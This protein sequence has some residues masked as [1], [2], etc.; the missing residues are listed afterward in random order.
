[1]QMLIQTYKTK[2]NKDLEALIKEK[3]SGYLQQ[4]FLVLLQ[5][6]WIALMGYRLTA[7]R[8]TLYIVRLTMLLR[9]TMRG[10]GNSA[11]T[12]MHL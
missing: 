10:K 12:K 7:T 2:F 6:S 3:T 11:L 4:L 9:C 5:V 8:P 1:M